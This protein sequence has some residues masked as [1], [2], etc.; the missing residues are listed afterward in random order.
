MNTGHLFHSFSFKSFISNFL[1]FS[2]MKI[3]QILHDP[4]NVGN[5]MS[6]SS[7][8]LKF[9]LYIWNFSVHVLLKPNLKDFDHNLASMWNESS[10]TV[11][12]TFFDLFSWDWNENR[13]FS[14]LWPLLSFLNLLTYWMWHFQQHHLLGF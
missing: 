10:C 14:V 6:N 4:M 3:L 7:A 8:S 12:W 13:P 1:V 5:L 11:V 9:R 2:R